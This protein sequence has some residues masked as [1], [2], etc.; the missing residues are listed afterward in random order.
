LSGD[1]AA[2]RLEALLSEDPAIAKHRSELEEMHTRL[3]DMQQR[4]NQFTT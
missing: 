2:T 1:Q 4:L 3:A